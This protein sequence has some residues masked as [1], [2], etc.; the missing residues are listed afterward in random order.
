MD[1]LLRLLLGVACF[2]G[3]FYGVWQMQISLW[4]K[5]SSSLAV[6]V[7]IVWVTGL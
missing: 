2:F 5:I 7:F 1:L 4:A 3:V 6:S